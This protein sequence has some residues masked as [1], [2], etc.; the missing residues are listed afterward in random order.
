MEPRYLFYIS[1]ED[2]EG[3]W[4]DHPVNPAFRDFK[5]DHEVSDESVVLKGSFSGTVTFI[6]KDFQL[7]LPYEQGAAR[8][9]EMYLVIKRKCGEEYIE[10]DRG[11]LL[12]SNGE[13]D[14]DRC[15]VRM[16][17]ESTSEYTEVEKNK[18]EVVNLLDIGLTRVQLNYGS[19]HDVEEKVCS[20]TVT[21]FKY[22][23]IEICGLDEPG[24][25]SIK[26]INVAYPVVTNNVTVKWIKPFVGN[27]L[28]TF[29]DPAK[30]TTEKLPEDVK[31][32]NTFIFD[33]LG[34]NTFQ[35]NNRF[36]RLNDVLSYFASTVFNLS[37]KSDFF[38]INPENASSINYV[39]GEQTQVA[40]LLLAQ[41]T[42]V[43]RPTSTQGATI[44]NITWEQLWNDLVTLFNLDYEVEDGTL[45]IEHVSFF[46][47][48]NVEDLTVMPKL[49]KW[50]KGMSKYSYDNDK[51]Y[52]EETWS[53]HNS[54]RKSDVLTR[55]EL[56]DHVGVPIYYNNGCT[57][58]ARGQR[59]KEWKTETLTPDLYSVLTGYTMINCNGEIYEKDPTSKDGL[60]IVAAERLSSTQYQMLSEPGILYTEQEVDGV[61]EKNRYIEPNNCLSVAHIQDKYFRHNRSFRFGY[62]ND[63]QETFESSVKAKIGREFKIPFCCHYEF[64][65]NAPVKT[66]LG[67]GEV[68]KASF[69]YHT[70]L[71]TLTVGYATD[72]YETPD[73]QAPLVKDDDFVVK[74]ELPTLLDVMANDENADGSIIEIIQQSPNASLEV[75]GS[76]VRYTGNIGYRNNL[77]LNT[78]ND[79]FVYRLKRGSVYS[80]NGMVKVLVNGV[81]NP[82]MPNRLGTDGVLDD[83]YT[84]GV[85]SVLNVNAAAGVLANDIFYNV[86]GSIKYKVTQV[87]DYD[88]E[89][90]NF[91]T[92]AM[93]PDGSFIYTP[94]AGFVGVDEF[95]YIAYFPGYD[96]NEFSL[97]RKA[98]VRIL[99]GNPITTHAFGEIINTYSV[100][101]TQSFGDLSVALYYDA[102]RI[103]PKTVA[104]LSVNT[105]VT[106]KNTKNPVTTED[107]VVNFNNV[108]RVIFQSNRQV[109]RAVESVGGVATNGYTVYVGTEPA[110]GGNNYEHHE[111]EIR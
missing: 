105:R 82:F 104:L 24:E 11:R 36:I 53:I 100:G 22:Y 87:Y 40:H 38:Q 83:K 80:N 67:T 55:L 59:K 64:D 2:S 99:V 5:R 8:C 102:D 15:T 16:K 76:Q 18:D 56:K 52:P 71:I 25:W 32:A 33:Y 94:D 7:L 26:E 96:P 78:P 103:F 3:D 42:D 51:Q 111:A 45:V 58:I 20:Q 44:A 14:L 49:E 107:S 97:Y 47:N 57:M 4:I 73:E 70:E 13:W 34:N 9:Q 75:V 43:Q 17:I 46:R 28:F 21:N 60:V 31:E 91:G 48:R 27:K 101:R 61:S 62:M 35:S 29:L 92:V 89:T 54:F 98:K 19:S 81:N 66:V 110:T 90:L 93:N 84:I 6:G 95:E 37:V 79:T 74:Q 85:D 109:F 30:S 68:Q 65:L 10:T 12:L 88:T 106:V 108:Q 41:I 72:E 63:R 39:T 69:D 23:D 77:P 86:N 1:I 50:L